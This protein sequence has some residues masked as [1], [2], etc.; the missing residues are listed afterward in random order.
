VVCALWPAFAA[1][2]DI[3]DEIQPGVEPARM[4]GEHEMSIK[5]KI[6]AAITLAL[7]AV[8]LSGCIPAVPCNGLGGAIFI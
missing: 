6:S 3:W 5:K 7:C 2:D 8:A 1:P 4:S